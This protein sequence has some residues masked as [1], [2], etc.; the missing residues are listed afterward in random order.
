[1]VV[2]LLVLLSGSLVDPVS[3][4]TTKVLRVV[5]PQGSEKVWW[6]VA[7]TFQ[8]EHPDV[9]VEL[10]IYPIEHLR[11]K[12][13]ISAATRD[14]L[15]DVVMVQQAW[16]CEFVEMGL[17]DLTE[18]TEDIG[19]EGITP[20]KCND[21]IFGGE[22]PH[23]SGWVVSVFR[24][25]RHREIAFELWKKA[26][27]SQGVVP[28]VK[29]GVKLPPAVLFSD[30]F[31]D[32]RADHWNL[33]PG[34][35]VEWQEGNY[36]LTGQGHRWAW[37]ESGLGWANYSFR[38]RVKLM[39]GGIRLNYRVSDEGRYFIDFGE[40]GLYLNKEAPWGNFFHLDKN[41][42]YHSLE[43]WHDVE[44]VCEG[45]RLQVYVDGKLEID[46][47]DDNPL[48]RGGIAFET[49]KDSHAYIDNVEVTRPLLMLR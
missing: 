29:G 36:V 38:S 45:R 32:G 49:T 18:H 34:W 14:S 8:E 26:A 30:D 28:L 3:A 10:E 15:L 6:T 47:T 25:S 40:E 42:T 37:P 11:E 27:K 9:N 43:V 19:E 17:E 2:C 16:L 13:F 4:Q 5:I 1:M 35:Q 12:L 7:K 33:E 39:T 24:H 44:I 20:V 21:R 22:W 41:D 46:Y 48:P 31:K 23:A